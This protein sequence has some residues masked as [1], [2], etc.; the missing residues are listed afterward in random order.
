MEDHLSLVGVNGSSNQNGVF[1]DLLINEG[2]HE[3]ILEK[4]SS[5]HP[6][7]INSYDAYLA[8]KI[9]MMSENTNQVDNLTFEKAQ[10]LAADYDQNG[11]VNSMDVVGILKEVVHISDDKD[12]MWIFYESDQNLSEINRNNSKLDENIITEVTSSKYT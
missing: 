8:F 4:E 12:P 11:R 10:I 1:E 7:A 6:K 3:F 9:G 2:S 5:F